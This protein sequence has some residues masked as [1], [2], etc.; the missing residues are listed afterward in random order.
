MV[1]YG[2]HPQTDV[3]AEIK[4]AGTREMANYS[5]SLILHQK[6][7]GSGTLIR[8]GD[9][10]GILTAA[11]VA[12]IVEKGSKGVRAYYRHFASIATSDLYYHDREMSLAE[13]KTAI[14]QLAL[15]AFSLIREHRSA[16]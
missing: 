8:V 3:P 6:L 4:D 15:C 11:H 16:A 10:H 12:R 14:E 5:V 1:E 13:I 7:I 9:Q 2:L